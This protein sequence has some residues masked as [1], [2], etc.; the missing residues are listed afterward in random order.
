[1][2]SQ[3]EESGTHYLTAEE[4]A[5]VFQLSVRTITRW[6]DAGRLPYVVV[7]GERRFELQALKGVVSRHDIPTG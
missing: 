6:A 4:V 7:D 5:R 1:M 2:A 3:E